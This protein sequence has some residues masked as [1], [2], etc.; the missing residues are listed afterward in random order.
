MKKQLSS[1]DLHFL[2]K[3]LKILEDSR[4]DKIYQAEKEIITFSF[5]KSNSGKKLLKINI[6]KCMHLIEG[7]EEFGETLGFG[8]FLRKHL[9]GVFLSEI[10]QLEPE[11]IIKF[12][13]KVKEEIKT[14]YIELFGKGN[15]ILCNENNVILNALEHHDFRERSIK[16]KLKYTYPIMNYNMFELKGDQLAGLLKDSKKDTIITSLATELGLGGLYSE[17]VCMLSNVDKSINPK[18]IDEKQIKSILNS[19]K[20]IINHKVNPKVILE[21]DKVIDFIPFD[22]EFYSDKKYEKKEFSTFNESVAYFYSQFI[23]EKETEYDKRLQSLQRI[24]EQQKSTIEE[25]KKDEKE[26]REKG[27][28]IYHNYQ[29]IKEVLEELNKASKKYSWKEIKE[30]LKNHKTIKDINEKDRKVVVEI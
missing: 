4:I 30:K 11:R 13:F 27:E 16:P 14:L 22:F 24:A 9:D 25:M 12:D 20:K 21:N 19:I 6:G 28:L 1:L 18:N 5:Y 23:E 3:E 7:K 26:M 17:E 8:M 2:V 15:I 10:S 29:L